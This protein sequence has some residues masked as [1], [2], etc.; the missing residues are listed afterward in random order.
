MTLIQQYNTLTREQQIE[1]VAFF[2]KKTGLSKTS[3][4]KHFRKPK[5]RDYEIAKEFFEQLKKD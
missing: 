1:L 3:F 2:M 4:F 5:E